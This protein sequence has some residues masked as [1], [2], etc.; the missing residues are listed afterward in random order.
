MDTRT[1]QGQNVH[2]PGLSE[3]VISNDC[4]FRHHG[5]IDSRC[6]HWWQFCLDAIHRPQVVRVDVLLLPDTWS[7]TR[8][9]VGQAAEGIPAWE[10]VNSFTHG[11]STRKE[12]ILKGTVVHIVIYICIVYNEYALMVILPLRVAIDD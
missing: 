8:V 7:D 5:P 11:F 6:C 9:A 12:T 10:A 1:L 4:R 3:I 2:F